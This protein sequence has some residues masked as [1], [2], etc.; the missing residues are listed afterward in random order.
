MYVTVR[1]EWNVLRPVRGLKR[2]PDGV[3]PGHTAAAHQVTSA[4]NSTSFAQRMQE[5]RIRAS[6]SMDAL[7]KQVHIP[8]AT[9]ANYERGDDVPSEDLMRRIL[10]SLQRGDGSSDAEEDGN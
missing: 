7:A 8:A 3:A 4:V 9:L 6:T 5:A 10:F 1:Q 2:S